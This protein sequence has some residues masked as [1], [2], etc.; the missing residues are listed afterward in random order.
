M[1]HH[2]RRYGVKIMLRNKWLWVVLAAS[3]VGPV[4]AGTPVIDQRE[5]NQSQRIVQGVRSGELNRTET[6]RLARGQ[7]RLHANERRAKADGTVT[8]R[9][10]VQLNRQAEVQSRRIHRQ[11]H[12]LQARP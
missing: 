5:K 3:L 4:M 10:R 7:Y 9:E 1:R 2:Q 12:D 8:T 6:K 11:K